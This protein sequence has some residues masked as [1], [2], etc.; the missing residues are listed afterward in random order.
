MY[1]DHKEGNKTRP[2]VTGCNSKTRG[3]SNSV[4]DL[5]E[6]M[7]KANLDPYETISREDMLARNNKKAEEIMKEGREHLHKKVM[8]KMG[9]GMKMI[10]R[11]DKL[12]KKK[13]NEASKKEEERKAKEDKN[14]K[15]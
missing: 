5:L 3:F 7:N 13:T 15:E 10:T 9:D 12:W 8:C 4:S 2:V 11:C 1:K 6:S 14:N